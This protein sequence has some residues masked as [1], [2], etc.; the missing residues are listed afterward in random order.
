MRNSVL[1]VEPNQIIA[2]MISRNIEDT[3]GMPVV[4]A[5]SKHD[6]VKELEQSE[7]FFLAIVSNSS[8]DSAPEE[9]INMVHSKKL[10]TIILVDSKHHLLSDTVDMSY[11]ACTSWKQRHHDIDYIVRTVKYINSNRSVTAL[12]VDESAPVRM[13]LKRQLRA[14][15]IRV[16][17]AKN[18][19]EAIDIV[20]CEDVSIVLTEYHLGEM[21]GL[22]LTRTLRQNY[23]IDELAILVVSS[24]DNS[25]ITVDLLRQGVNDIIAKPW[26]H[27]ILDSRVNNAVRAL[28]MYQKLSDVANR[29][30]LTN[31][32]NRRYFFTELDKSDTES[33]ARIV[34]MMD[35]DKFKD[36]NDTYGHDVGDMVLRRFADILREKVMPFGMVGRIGG[37]E[38]AILFIGKSLDEVSN[39]LEAMRHTVEIEKIPLTD[40]N[41]LKFTVS[42]GVSSSSLR[43]GQVM[44]KR[45]DELLYKAKTTGRNKVVTE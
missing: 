18:G 39:V 37:E 20:K 38:F 34:A 25:E 21:N 42:T 11:V 33:R 31:H 28:E 23:T 44:L 45:A 15:Q 30:Y 12:I 7:R 17:E 5:L 10:S 35:L 36:V 26:V 16:L 6:T 3:H 9:L 27:E 43:S 19:R 41:E 1:V 2:E 4:I 22:E 40:G 32:Y 29:D 8:E 14:Q 24:E 13:L